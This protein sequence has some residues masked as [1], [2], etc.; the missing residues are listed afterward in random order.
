[1]VAAAAERVEWAMLAV[2]AAEATAMAVAGTAMAVAGTVRVEAAQTCS[3]KAAAN[4]R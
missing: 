2:T 3:S 4:C 1:M